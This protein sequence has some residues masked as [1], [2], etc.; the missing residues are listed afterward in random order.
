VE[1]STHSPAVR[2]LPS[3]LAS[4]SIPCRAGALATGVKPSSLPSWA[5]AGVGV[6]FG[7]RSLL[8]PRVRAI[9]LLDRSIKPGTSS[10]R[11]PW[12]PSRPCTRATPCAIWNGKRSWCPTEDLIGGRWSTDR[13][14]R[15]VL[16]GVG[17]RSYYAASPGHRLMRRQPPLP[18]ALR[19]RAQCRSR[20]AGVPAW[21]SRSDCGSRTRQRPGQ[22]AE[23]GPPGHQGPFQGHGRDSHPAADLASRSF[24]GPAPPHRELV[25]PAARPA[26]LRDKG[27]RSPRGPGRIRPGRS[28][29]PPEEPCPATP[30]NSTCCSA[31]LCP[32]LRAILA[33]ARAPRISAGLRTNLIAAWAPRSTG[34][35]QYFYYPP[36]ESVG[37]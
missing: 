21:T 34:H 32:G 16:V 5:A 31:S 12:A 36:R 17:W 24:P 25:R 29:A 19:T 1:R 30:T 10:S 6:G 23:R 15:R 20:S 14:D 11:A 28:Y 4:A 8:Q 33:T 13:S 18:R 2:I 7:L 3:R 35:L 22:R 27:R 37:P 26:R 9:L